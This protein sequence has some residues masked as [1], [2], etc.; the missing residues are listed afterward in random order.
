MIFIGIFTVGCSS[1]GFKDKSE[2]LKRDKDSEFNLESSIQFST[3]SK[4]KIV[5]LGKLSKV[6]GIVK[7]YHPKA[8]S[9]DIN[10]DAELFRIMPVILEED[11][12]VNAVLYQ[13]IYS[14]EA[15][16][17][18]INKDI[19]SDEEDG[20]NNDDISSKDKLEE[21]ELD[22]EKSTEEKSDNYIIDAKRVQLSPSTSWCYDED[23]LGENLSFA[24]INLLETNI[25]D[26]KNA[27][28][29]FHDD[30][31][32][33]FMDNEKSYTSIIYKKS[34]PPVRHCTQ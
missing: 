19:I 33:Q 13:W 7:Y 5:D 9:G 31:V 14:L 21:K 17:N 10:M 12:D 23:Y 28:V 18:D 11:S 16:E 15:Q 32:Y 2:I 30:S 25:F 29:S 34:T 20:F 1:Q 6:W 24:L 4:E 3:I 22:K 26:R 8:I 27:Y